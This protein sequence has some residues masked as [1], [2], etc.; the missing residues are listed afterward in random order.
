MIPALFLLAVRMVEGTRWAWGLAIGYVATCVLGEAIVGKQF[1]A[2]QQSLYLVTGGTI[3][4]WCLC[5]TRA[6]APR[7]PAR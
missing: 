1:K 2:L 4:L 5:L 7:E 3:A 6:F